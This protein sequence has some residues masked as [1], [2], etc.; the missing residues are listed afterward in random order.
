MPAATQAIYDGEENLTQGGVAV[1]TV[2]SSSSAS[3]QEAFDEPL[4]DTQVLGIAGL[5]IKP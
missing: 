2:T 1:N 4:T 3:I 5:F